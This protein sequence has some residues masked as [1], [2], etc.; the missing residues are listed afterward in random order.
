MAKTSHLL[1]FALTAQPRCCK[2]LWVSVLICLRREPKMRRK[3][4]SLLYADGQSNCK[5]STARTH[6]RT[7]ARHARLEC[8]A[9]ARARA[10]ARNCS[11]GSLGKLDCRIN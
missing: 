3:E 2:T 7:H 6:A 10:H 9:R 8:H 11:Q 4:A 1:G 5:T